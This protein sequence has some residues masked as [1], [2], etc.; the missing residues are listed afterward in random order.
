[1]PARP[2]SL[3]DQLKSWPLVFLPHQLL[4]RLVR[5]AT[6]W[7]SDWLKNVMIRLFIRHFKVDM[8]DA[9]TP[10]TEDY[11]DFNHFFTRA[12][13]AS[14]RPLPGDSQAIISPVDG[15]VSPEM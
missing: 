15:F 8:N 2:A 5:I 6:R 11:A 14:A 4:S 12:L 7:Q 9:E 10:D 3:L 1:M 13:K